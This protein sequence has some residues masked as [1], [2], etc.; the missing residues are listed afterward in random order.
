MSKQQS[1]EQRGFRGSHGAWRMG[2]CQPGSGVATLAKRVFDPALGYVILAADA[3]CVDPE[4]DSDAV[5]G[6]F[7]DLS[8][9]YPPLSHVETQ[10]CRRS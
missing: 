8:R 2:H 6:P 10:A 4:Q 9:R 5:P 3:L 7:G 1:P